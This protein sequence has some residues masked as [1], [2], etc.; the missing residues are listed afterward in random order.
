MLGIPANHWEKK[1]KK[2]KNRKHN[3]KIAKGYEHAN[4]QKGGLRDW[5]LDSGKFLDF[6]GH[7]IIA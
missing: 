6:E 4:L 3:R 5:Q 7:E 1:E 2:K